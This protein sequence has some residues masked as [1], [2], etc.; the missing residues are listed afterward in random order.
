[1]LKGTKELLFYSVLVLCGVTSQHVNSDQSSQ[2]P[3]QEVRKQ[4]TDAQLRMAFE[5]GRQFQAMAE[6]QLKSQP[7]LPI[8]RAYTYDPNA[9]HHYYSPY[10][11]YPPVHPYYPY[12]P[13]IQPYY[14]TRPNHN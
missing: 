4:P 2:V 1:M 9:R 13:L 6:Q 5:L 3:I 7:G 10:Y 12:A 8:P 14:P 11:Y